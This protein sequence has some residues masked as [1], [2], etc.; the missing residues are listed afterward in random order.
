MSI[1]GAIKQSFKPFNEN[2]LHPAVAEI[3]VWFGLTHLVW[4]A[5]G[6]FASNEWSARVYI[7]VLDLAPV[8]AWSAL[9]LVSAGMLLWAG[10]SKKTV[11][12]RVGLLLFTFIQTMWAASFLFF[13]I[14][15]GGDVSGV[16]SLLMFLSGPVIA[17]IVL[18]RPLKQVTQT[19]HRNAENTTESE[20]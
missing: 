1:A 13:I 18:G 7:W 20:K 19:V 4:A 17:F 14:D 6:F 10:L 8:Q 5:L 9:M 15:L 11:A 16:V 2:G 12:A 3:C